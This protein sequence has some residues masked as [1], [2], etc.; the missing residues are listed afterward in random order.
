[1]CRLRRA[2]TGWCGQLLASCV[3]LPL[4]AAAGTNESAANGTANNAL[5]FEAT[6]APFSTAVSATPGP[7]AGP[8]FPI[9]LDGMGQVQALHAET[10]SVP[11]AGTL[12]TKGFSVSMKA[13]GWQ[14]IGAEFPPG[15]WPAE[16]S[17]PVRLVVF[18]ANDEMTS[19]A[20]EAGHVLAALSVDFSPSVTFRKQ[21]TIKLPLEPGAVAPLPGV[22]HVVC[23]YDAQAR[24]WQKRKHFSRTA[25][26]ALGYVPG[27]TL[28]FSPYAALRVRLCAG[29][30]LLVW[31]HGNR[32]FDCLHGPDSA[33]QIPRLT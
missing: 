29:S 15:A 22:E 11:D 9:I 4:A 24:R 13:E 18:A 3:L 5:Q 21:V 26:Y 28:S 31:C 12:E 27:E 16:V 20:R 30:V 14:S 6:W 8:Y 10:F 1:M 33:A 7:A 32:P 2:A 19:A 23:Y 17:G 25:N